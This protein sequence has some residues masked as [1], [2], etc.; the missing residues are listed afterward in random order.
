[1][2]KACD[3]AKILRQGKILR[4]GK[5]LATWPPRRKNAAAMSHGVW[6]ALAM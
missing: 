2:P 5:G 4:H 3:K 6:K 1:M